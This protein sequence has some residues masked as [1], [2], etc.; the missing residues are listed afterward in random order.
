MPRAFKAVLFGL[1]IGLSGL[2]TCLTPLSL[3]VEENLGLHL[4]FLLRGVQEAPA[5]VVVVAIDRQSAKKL[6]LPPEP[7][8]WPRT[9]HAQLVNRLKSAGAAVI[10]FDMIFNE[11]QA[12]ENDRAFAQAIRRANNVVLAQS[13][14]REKLPITDT[15]GTHAANVF[16]EEVVPPIALLA[17]AAIAQAPF[18]LPKVPIKLSRYWVIKPEAGDIPTM[19]VVVFH[20]YAAEALNRLI[21][22]VRALKPDQAPTMSIFEEGR[23]LSNQMVAVIQTLHALFNQDP[24]VA[25]QML[26]ELD[27]LQASPLS[28]RIHQQLRIMIHLYQAGHSRYLNF[29]GPAGTIKTIPYYQV[30]GQ[31][32]ASASSPQIPDLKGKVVFVGQTESYW[33]K[34]KDG[35]YT[36][37]TPQSGVDISGVEIAASAFANLLEGRSVDPL[38]M[39]AHLALV[40]GWG[41]AVALISCRLPASVSAAVLLGLGGLYLMQ[42]LFQ[43][44][45]SGAWYPIVVPLFFQSPLAYFSALIGKY[46]MV[47][48]ERQN[49]RDAF[50]Y[51]LPDK[52]VDQ[53][54]KNIKAIQ[55][56]S[57]VVYS[58]CLF[59][60]AEQYTHISEGMD[61]ESLTHLMNQ[62]YEAIFKPIKANSGVVLQV[63]GDSVLSL[64]TAPQPDIQLKSKAC[65]AAL[66]IADSVERFNRQ[67]DGHALPTRIG[68]HAGYILL[69]NIGAVDHFEYRPVGDIVNTASRLEGLNKYLG[70]RILAS[71]QVVTHLDGFLTRNMGKF[72]FIG[73]SKPIMVYELITHVDRSDKQLD[74]TCRHFVHGI[75]AF[76]QRSWD[77][78]RDAFNQVLKLNE[79]EDG[80]SRFYLDLC[81]QYRQ[82]PPESDW[83][84]TVYLKQK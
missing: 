19:P 83:D 33:P 22:L 64:W 74:D 5:E 76:Q 30:A 16:I 54:A 32:D 82:K 41:I 61:P 20:A 40:M 70:T 1:G 59:T 52:V 60:D 65:T 35:F 39:P 55:S 38:G 14:A 26:L 2:L 53:L 71:E 13:V 73:K 77:R 36:V 79:P 7:R 4:L 62:Y 58:I 31:W 78:A 24:Q 57:Q 68:M 75:D 23:F 72:M 8:K 12:P 63:I 37:F 27:R 18:L 21:A 10:A 15:R 43:F 69:G 66:E 46:R 49:I 51:Y 80:P 84:G 47:S 9:L 6:D 3:T 28:A 50:G 17:D 29:Y 34:A 56:E 11:P 45:S 25:N 67:S 81:K 42:A 44:K 48:K